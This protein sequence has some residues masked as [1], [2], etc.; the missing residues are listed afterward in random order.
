[1]KSALCSTCYLNRLAS[2][3]LSYYRR[4]GVQAKATGRNAAAGLA[5]SGIKLK[6]ESVYGI[7]S[8]LSAL[9]ARKRTP[10]ALYIK[11]GFDS[12]QQ[13]QQQVPSS[14]SSS[15]ESEEKKQLLKSIVAASSHIPV[16]YVDKN[17]LNILS[18]NNVHQ[19][20]T[21]VDILAAS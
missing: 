2:F 19:G 7:H 11:K 17:L 20:G 13:Q 9:R 16:H 15:R 10:Y 4:I 14:P 3:S 5:E 21:A 8:V 1:M 18:A 12:E 6:G